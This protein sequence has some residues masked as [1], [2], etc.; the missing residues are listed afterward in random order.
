M[1]AHVRLS[2]CC[3]LLCEVQRF[4]VFCCVLVFMRVLLCYD[5]SMLVLTVV[6]VSVGMRARARCEDA[7]R[8]ELRAEQVVSRRKKLRASPPNTLQTV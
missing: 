5:S 1:A 6:L 7:R 3:A 8:I 4:A 2:V